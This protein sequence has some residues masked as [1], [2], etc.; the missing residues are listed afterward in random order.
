MIQKIEKLLNITLSDWVKAIIIIAGV[1]LSLILFHILWPSKMRLEPNVHFIS[2][3]RDENHHLLA[4]FGKNTVLNN[5]LT[6]EEIHEMDARGILNKYPIVPVL[7]YEE[8]PEN[9]IYFLT[10]V[11]NKNFFGS[12]KD[13]V[14]GMSV[15][16]VARL[17]KG[18]ADGGSNIPQQ[19]LKNAIHKKEGLGTIYLSRKYG[20]QL[21]AF[22]MVKS[23]SPQEILMAY[24]NYSGNFWYEKDF[25]GLI[26]ASY[27][28]FNRPPHELNDLEMLLTVRTLKNARDL[29]MLCDDKF[30][31]AAVIKQQVISYFALIAEDSQEDKTRLKAMRGMELRFAERN[32]LRKT[33]A[34]T[35]FF[36]KNRGK[37]KRRFA[38]QYISSIKRDNQLKLDEAVGL[39]SKRFR[40]QL[41]KQGYD[42][43]V[44]LIALDIKSGRIEAAL[45]NRKNSGAMANFTDYGDGFQCGSVLKPLV[46]LELFENYDFNSNSKLFNGNLEEYKYNPSN[47]NNNLLNQ[48]VSVRDVLKYSLNKAAV[49][50]R[51]KANPLEVAR[52]VE[53]KLSKMEIPSNPSYSLGESY[54]LGTK[55]MTPW[56]VAQAYQMLFNDGKAVELSPWKYIIDPHLQDTIVDGNSVKTKSIYTSESA[57]NLKSVLSA[58]FERGGTCHRLLKILPKDRNYYGKTGT[59]GKAK[60]GWTVI[61]D[62]QKLVIAWAGYVKNDEGILKRKD[63]PAVPSKSGAGSAG[64]LAAMTYSKLYN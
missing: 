38:L 56:E 33:T 55:T 16:G 60:D 45:G 58:A 31:N 10:R 1:F 22:Q 63:A 35:N 48:D 23:A 50:Y 39:F 9:Y 46:F 2:S 25:S 51:V 62:G 49:N 17:F 43:E 7:S 34:L 13:N 3:V 19:L 57:S 15:S 24:T 59:T 18:K 5:R 40:S 14:Y 53:R 8:L 28:I 21:A 26:L 4:V 54:I 61:S 11:E 44:S 41:E 27:A 29:R 20:E 37:T 36:S 30:E 6:A 32:G 52:R 42:L 47:F 64:I 12:G